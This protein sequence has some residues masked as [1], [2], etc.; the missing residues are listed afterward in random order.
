SPEDRL[1]QWQGLV[2]R[3]IGEL[4]AGRYAAAARSAQAARDQAFALRAD[5]EAWGMVRAAHPRLAPGLDK[6]AR[7]KLE[8]SAGRTAQARLSRLR[9]YAALLK[10]EN[11]P[12]TPAP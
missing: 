12:G 6:E 8:I 5:P 9:G 10:P 7:F 3:E 2:A 1:A 11:A 4:E